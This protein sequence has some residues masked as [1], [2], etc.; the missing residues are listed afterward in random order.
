MTNEELKRPRT[1]EQ[2]SLGFDSNTHTYVVTLVM[3]PAMFLNLSFICKMEIII[4]I[5][6][7]KG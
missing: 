3:L 2:C 5:I 7:L 4:T 1:L 6:F